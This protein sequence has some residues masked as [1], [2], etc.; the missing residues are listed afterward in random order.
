MNSTVELVNSIKLKIDKNDISIL[1]KDSALEFIGAGRSAVVFKIQSTD[2]ALKVFFP[3]CTSI[4]KEEA[5]IYEIL[6]GNPYFP[7]LYEAGDNYL[8][9]DYIEGYTLFECLTQG[10]PL[11]KSTI[12]ETDHA[13]SLARKAGLNPSDIHLRNII[14]TPEGKIKLIDVARFRQTKDCRQWTD[15]KKVFFTF[16]S[17]SYFPKKFPVSVLNTVA[18][19]YKKNIIHVA[20]YKKSS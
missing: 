12:S 4:A 14:L 1:E 17:K 3:D 11:T 8:L 2:K 16:Y 10:I 19:L 20:S 13:L 5:E 15:L 18:Y 9:I 7:T 6:K